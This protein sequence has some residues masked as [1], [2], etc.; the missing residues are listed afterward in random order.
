[1]IIDTDTTISKVCNDDLTVTNNSTLIITGIC[2]KKV[3]V[4]ENS[5]VIVS[6]VCKDLEILKNSSAKIS[7]TVDH[8][9]NR[10]N[11]VISGIVDNLEDFSK[12]T[13]IETGA[14]VNGKEF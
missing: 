4:E 2:D 13:T 14:Y 7:G 8:L 5:N 9:I 3:I 11:V 12:N 1:M 10:G 6:G